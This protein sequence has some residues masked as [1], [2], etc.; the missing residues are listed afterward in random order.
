[1][2]SK[3]YIDSVGRRIKVFGF[4][5]SYISLMGFGGRFQQTA[6]RKNIFQLNW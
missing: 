6:G 2:R 4:S 3:S 1:M 5:I